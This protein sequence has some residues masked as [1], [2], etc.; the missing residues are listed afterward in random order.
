MVQAL[1]LL[2]LF[3]FPSL[4]H[5]AHST[6]AFTQTCTKAPDDCNIPEGK[7]YEPS[8][9]IYDG[10]FQCP[11]FAGIFPTHKYSWMYIFKFLQK[12]KKVCLSWQNIVVKRR[13]SKGSY[14]F[15]IFFIFS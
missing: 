5:L 2:K 12:F 1:M 7:I 3:V 9:Y 6:C 8:N 4:I 15:F 13:A 10:E 14:Y 11:E